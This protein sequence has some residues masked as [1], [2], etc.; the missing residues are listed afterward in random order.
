MKIFELNTFCG[1]STGR[2]AVSIADYAAKQGAQTVLGFGADKAVPPQAEAYALR[3]G[4]KLG[5]KWHGALRKLLD[6]EGCGSVWA[7]RRLIG[8]LKQYKPDVIHLHNLHGCYINHR[9]LFRYLQKAN[10]PVLWTLHDCW[11]FTGH[12]AYFDRVGCERWK[13]QCFD[14]PQKHAYP[15]S[16]GLDGS[17]CNYARKR[18]LFTSLPNLTL[19]APC[20]WLTEKLADSYLS[21]IPVRILYNGVEQSY[22]KQT[23]SDLREHYA[24]GGKR[25]VLAVAS[26]WEERKGFAYLPQLARRLGSGYRLVVIGLSQAQAAALGGMALCI[27]RTESAE[28]LAAWYSAADCFI[29]P[30]LEDNMPMVNL[31]ALACGT[32]VAAFDTGGCAEAI[33]PDYGIVVPKGDVEALVAA[34]QK[35]APQKDQ[36]QN[37]CLLQAEH[38]SAERS[39]AGYWELY[40][41]AMR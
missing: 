25:L 41:E 3:V 23:P 22:F 17:R 29:N 34:A 26:E 16:V 40:R 4:G 30:T 1:G 39:A 32:P 8:F 35:L 15:E 28:E 10:V 36:L 2:I 38:F 5:R 20:R 14:C 37:A 6:A 21:G 13:T 33:T 9:L 11:A 18:A 24:L 19:V 12:C 31:E 7:T 27:P